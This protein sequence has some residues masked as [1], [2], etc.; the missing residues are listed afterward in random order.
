MIR[1]VG[2][3]TLRLT[4]D[5]QHGASVRDF[6]FL[7]AKGD[8]VPVLRPTDPANPAVEGAAMFPMV[9]FANRARGNFLEIG[10]AKIHLLRNTADPLAIHGFGWQRAWCVV[11]QDTCSCTLVLDVGRDMPLRFEARITV[12]LDREGAEFTLEMTNP[13]PDPI[14]AGLGWHPYFPQSPR[15][16]L[17]FDCETFWL[18]GPDDLP[19]F[20]LRVPP[21]LDFAAAR[22][23]PESW[24][25]NCYEAWSGHAVIEQPDLGYRLE[26]SAD[27]PLN[28]LMFYAP[29]T[30]VFALEPQS[31]VSGRTCLGVGGLQEIHPGGTLAA[32]MR[33]GVIPVSN[34]PVRRSETPPSRRSVAR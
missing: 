6:D 30:G 21:E 5:P 18:Q 24:R 33:L 29:Q 4:L 8:W 1:L 27:P 7:N 15:T 14:P 32:R 13:N 2:N 11:Q 28:H 31:H 9:P 26:M 22:A 10:S 20:P 19:T 23:V 3:G 12:K 16:T 34:D 25:D 17:Q